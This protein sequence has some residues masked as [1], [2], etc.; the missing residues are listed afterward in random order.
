MWCN[1]RDTSE[2]YET[3]R[4]DVKWVFFPLTTHYRDDMSRVLFYTQTYEWHIEILSSNWKIEIVAMSCRCGAQECTSLQFFF[5]SR[6]YFLSVVP[7]FS[8]LISKWLTNCRKMHVIIGPSVVTV[9]FFSGSLFF[10]IVISFVSF[11]TFSL[12]RKTTAYNFQTATFVVELTNLQVSSKS[13][14]IRKKK[15]KQNKDANIIIIITSKV[16]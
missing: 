13:K 14:E 3:F 16:C 1:Q 2:Q 4:I 11:P 6:C 7:F 15:G 9:I 8:C 12:W 10:I 5:S